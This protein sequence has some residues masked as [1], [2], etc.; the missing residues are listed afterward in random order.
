MMKRYINNV[1]LAVLIFTTPMYINVYAQDA[2]TYYNT[3]IQ[4]K[5]QKDYKGSIEAFN[6]A[7][8]LKP[9]FSDVYFN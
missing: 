3:G 4:K 8:E 7:I 5:D 2:Q 9:D 6:K 1:L